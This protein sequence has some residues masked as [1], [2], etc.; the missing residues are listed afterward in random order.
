VWLHRRALLASPLL[1][2]VIACGSGPDRDGDGFPEQ[3]DCDDG[4][5]LVFPGAD[6]YCNGADDDCDD[7]VDEDPVDGQTWYADADGDG[8]GGDRFTTVAC[9]FPTGYQPFSDDCDDGDPDVHP[10][11]DERCNGVDDDC[12]DDIDEDAVDPATWY[13]DADRDGYGDP[14]G[15]VQ[16]CDQP[17][18]TADN[19]DD[20]D[21]EDAT[22]NPDGTWYVDADGDGFGVDG[23]QQR[24][25]RPY[26]G[27]A[28]EPGDCSDGDASL[29][30]GADEHCDGVDEDCDGVIDDDPVDAPSWYADV[31]GDGFGDDA[32]LT[33]ACEQPDEHV[34]VGGDCLDDDG[35]S[36]PG[37]P[38]QCGDDVDQ[39]CNGVADNT[40]ADA[41]VAEDLAIASLAGPALSTTALGQRVALWDPDGDGVLDLAAA[42]PTWDG[43]TD[44]GLGRVYLV[45]GPLSGTLDADT[46]VA[47]LTGGTEADALGSRL[48][49]VDDADGAGTPGLL[50]AAPGWEGDTAGYYEQGV[51]ALYVGPQAGTLSLEDADA[52]VEGHLPGMELGAGPVG[53][54][55]VD[56]DGLAELL[57]PAP[58]SYDGG[59][60]VWV[61]SGP[62]SGT[63]QTSD[64]ELRV[65]GEAEGLGFGDA[66][67]GGGDLDGDG[68]DDLAVGATAWRGAAYVFSGPLDGG[69]DSR[70]AD[71]FVEGDELGGADGAHLAMSDLDGDGRDDLL[72]GAPGRS[73][74]GGVEGA[75]R[76]AIL[77]GDGLGLDLD[78]LL[79]ITGTRPGL[80]LGDSAGGLA[81]ED[82]DGDGRADIA[83]GAPHDPAAGTDAGALCLLFGPARGAL[84]H[85]RCDARLLGAGTGAALGTDLSLGRTDGEATDLAVGSTY[86]STLGG[87]VLLL[88]LSSL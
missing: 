56:G 43:P 71:Q 41:L 84:D 15:T 30:P 37:A 34:D 13:A 67:A 64:A 22:D 33:A 44:D 12:D 29:H 35:D 19:A 83:I 76:V 77:A 80:A 65:V 23:T 85:D 36:Y 78:P 81:F 55:D 70:D 25:C 51:L 47:T 49:V 74:S 79:T 3:L 20:C 7:V 27:Y 52:R 63:M 8:Y 45:A 48:A 39:D 54:G 6:E 38:E 4:D 87:E 62:L 16:A 46:A 14:A 69:M 50:V 66:V 32:A 61:F 21:D 58:A 59:G 9:D 88:S 57:L 75:G 40:C 28:L 17:P 82:L 5:A 31:D 2:L 73:S 60:S 18:D 72:V 86:G 53:Q 1:P 10:G 24:G 26:E 42:A 68:I 11:A